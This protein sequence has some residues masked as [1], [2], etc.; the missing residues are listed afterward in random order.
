MAA[1]KKPTTPP[2]A[3]AFVAP[4][5]TDEPGKITKLTGR[6]SVQ[7]PG[8]G[9]P[10]EEFITDKQKKLGEVDDSAKGQDP[11]RFTPK[12]TL[13]DGIKPKKGLWVTDAKGRAGRITTTYQLYAAVEWDD[14]KT[15]TVR[16]DKLNRRR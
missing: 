8:T 10:A 14:G 4:P 6:D 3:T 1:R 16:N 12:A 13:A 7:S 15:Q 5:L 2:E 9:K 11:A